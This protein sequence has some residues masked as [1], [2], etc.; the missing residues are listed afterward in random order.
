MKPDSWVK[1]FIIFL[2]VVNGLLAVGGVIGAF[3]SDET[4]PILTVSQA[5]VIQYHDAA[6]KILYDIQHPPLAPSRSYTARSLAYVCGLNLIF[7]T[8][9]VVYGRRSETSS[10]SLATGDQTAL[11]A[12]S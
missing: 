10:T 11:G 7:L 2:F 5:D 3:R 12:S 9:L 4:A 8:L 6:G 1:N